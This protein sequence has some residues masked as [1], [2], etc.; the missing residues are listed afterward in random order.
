[1]EELRSR[2]KVIKEDMK[3]LEQLTEM[4]RKETSIFESF[5]KVNKEVL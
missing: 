4:I 2:L 3:Q 1:M 5:D